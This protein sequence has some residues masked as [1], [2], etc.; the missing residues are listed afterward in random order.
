MFKDRNREKHQRE[1]LQAE[2]RSVISNFIHGNW[3]RSVAQEYSEPC[4][5]SNDTIKTDD[6]LGDNKE[7]D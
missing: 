6:V 1:W 4:S 2:R 3:T 7:A 5:D